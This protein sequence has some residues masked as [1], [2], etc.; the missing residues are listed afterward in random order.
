MNKK[1]LRVIGAAGA[2][3]ILEF[4]DFT[5]YA[6]FASTIAMLFFPIESLE[7]SLIATFG[8]FAIGF[9]VRPLGAILFGHIGDK[10]GRKTSLVFS[11]LLMAF[12]TF[13]IG[14]IPT[15]ES[16]GIWAPVLLTLCRLLQGICAGGE[17]TGAA[18]F[19]LE[20]ILP[21]RR[22]LVGGIL[23]LTCVGGALLASLIAIF[24]NSLNLPDWKWRLAFMFGGIIGIISIYI[25]LKLE[26]TK[27]FEELRANKKI[28]EIP[29]LSV[30][31]EQKKSLF[32]MITVGGL[33]GATIYTLFGY[34]VSYLIHTANISSEIAYMSSIVG[35][36]S[37]MITAPFFGHLADRLGSKVIMFFG[38][39]GVSIFSYI[40][41][42]GFMSQDI[43]TIFVSQITL[44]IL[45]AMYVGPQHLF[46]LSLFSPEERM[47]GISLGY[48]LGMA[49]I[50][51]TTPI[52]SSYLIMKTGDATTPFL[53]LSFSAI[54]AVISN[55]LTSFPIIKSRLLVQD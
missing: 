4:Y 15:Y 39:S 47:T 52:I 20:H 30:L 17:Y 33:N 55:R 22:G 3:N 18:I 54:L 41:Y 8:I 14:I 11:I 5:L 19:T 21:K 24:I 34:S 50:G 51:G 45:A 10:Y 12:P 32:T 23:I 53:W 36:V 40:Y 38:A 43:L 27:V 13:L 44:G 46:S 48:A 25:R 16:I 29:L 35:L 26:E 2:G 9:V 28:I 1:D 42:T 7:L 37:L 6:A 49:L 31:R